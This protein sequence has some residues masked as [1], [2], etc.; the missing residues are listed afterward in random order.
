MALRRL[1]CNLR[2]PGFGRVPD[3]PRGFECASQPAVLSAAL[4][5]N[6]PTTQPSSI[7]YIESI[8]VH[9]NNIDVI[10]TDRAGNRIHDLQQ[11]DFELRENNA[12]Q[13]I[14]NFSE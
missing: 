2:A 8:E 12:P 7:P 10:V 14:T 6:S 11:G 9:V 13:L 5:S 3:G 1:A 4:A